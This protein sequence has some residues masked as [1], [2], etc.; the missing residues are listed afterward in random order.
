[1]SDPVWLAARTVS[2]SSIT[3][4]G[5]N[6]TAPDATLIALLAAMGVDA[7]D[8]VKAGTALRAFDA[9]H[10]DQ[11]IAPLVVLRETAR[12]WTLRY[13]LPRALADCPWRFA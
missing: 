5:A 8:D 12:P 6:T 4:F 3:T 7:A 9:A 2:R 1:M 10:D 11:R 13:R